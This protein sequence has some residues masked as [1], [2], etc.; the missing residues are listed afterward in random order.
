MKDELPNNGYIRCMEASK[1]L[2]IHFFNE[3]AE[4]LSSIEE[5]EQRNEELE[6]ENDRLHRM[7][8][9][10]H[11]LKARVERDSTRH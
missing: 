9:L 5:L 8:R 2:K 7:L 10:Q 1:H 11:A 4:A 6:K 3:R